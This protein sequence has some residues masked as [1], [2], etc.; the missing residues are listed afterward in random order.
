MQLNPEKICLAKTVA[1][2]CKEVLDSKESSGEDF[3]FS[4]FLPS[5]LTQLAGT[6]SSWILV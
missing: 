3:L 2:L 4:S 1:G 6:C 5:V